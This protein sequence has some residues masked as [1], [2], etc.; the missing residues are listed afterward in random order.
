MTPT[1][2]RLLQHEERGLTAPR[3][4]SRL[5]LGQT[6]CLEPWITE[7]I[8]I[9][10]SENMVAAFNARAQSE[11]KGEKMRAIQA[12]LCVP[13]DEAPEAVAGPEFFNL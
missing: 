5:T 2:P 3:R 13:D 7:S 1:A 11:G 8:G 6:Q 10:L 12:N 4:H 9:D